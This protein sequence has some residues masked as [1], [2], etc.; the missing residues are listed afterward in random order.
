V[1]AFEKHKLNKTK[2]PPD[3]VWGSPK[4]YTEL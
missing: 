2:Y 1:A 3:K 4:K